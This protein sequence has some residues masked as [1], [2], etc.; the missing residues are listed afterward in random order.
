[1]TELS[2]GPHL[3]PE[4]LAQRLG[5]SVRKLDRM[6]VDGDGPPWMR[7]GPRIILYPVSEVERWEQARLCTSRA[8]EM[9]RKGRTGPPNA[10]PH[11]LR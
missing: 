8:A 10:K 11:A 7:V 6:R 2:T 3:R 9:Q 4:K 1:M 5:C